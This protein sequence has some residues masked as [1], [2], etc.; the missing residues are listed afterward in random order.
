LPRARD[1][2]PCRNSF[3]AGPSLC[4]LSGLC[5]GLVI[6]LQGRLEMF[7]SAHVLLLIEE[8]RALRPPALGLCPCGRRVLSRPELLDEISNM[9]HAIADSPGALPLLPTCF[10]T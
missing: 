4:R 2:L 5:F 9:R 8:K 1:I 3:V 6:E 7:D 10:A